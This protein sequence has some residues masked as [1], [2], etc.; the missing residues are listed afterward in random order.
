MTITE[1]KTLLTSVN[2]FANKVAYY[3]WPLNEAPALPFVCYFSPSETDFAADNINYYHRPRFR[4]ELYTKTRDLSTEALFEAAF[5]NA[6]LYFTKETEFI[7]DERCWM[8]VF[9]L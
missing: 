9:S 5:A 7:E 3:E 6:G 1:M 4:V 8:T 2:G